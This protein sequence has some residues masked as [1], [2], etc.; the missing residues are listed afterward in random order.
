VLTNVVLPY[1]TTQ[2][3]DTGMDSRYRDLMTPETVAP[4]VT[5]LVDPATGLNG[6]VLVCAAGALRAA[7]AMEFGTVRLPGGRLTP[8]QLR[9]HIDRSRCA[10]PREYPEALSAFLDLAGEVAGE[11]A[12]G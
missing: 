7:A 6:Q 11:V 2:M 12:S 5:A 4:V 9:E 10:A 8:A 1:A 3:T